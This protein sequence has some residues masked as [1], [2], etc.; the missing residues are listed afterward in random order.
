[1]TSRVGIVA[2]ITLSIV[3]AGCGAGRGRSGVSD[4]SRTSTVT[5]TIMIDHVAVPYT[6][7]GTGRPCLVMGSPVYYARVFSSAFKKALRCAYVSHRG[8]VAGAPAPHGRPF[9]IDAAVEEFETARRALGFDRFVLVGHSVH[10]LVAL[11]YAL[12]YPERVSHVIAIDAPPALGPAMER[13]AEEHWQTHA[14]AGRKDAD[15]LNRA[16]LTIASSRQLAPSD[17]FVAAYVADAARLWADSTYDASWLWRDVTVNVPRVEELLDLAGAY[18]LRAREPVSVPVFVAM[19][20]HDYAIPSVL[21]EGFHG[22]FRD[23]TIEI[24]EHSG[25]TPPLEEAA[26]FDRRVLGWLARR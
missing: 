8:Y 3:T 23:V 22:P 6:I 9:T 15:R 4:S 13:Q 10:G 11:A 20:R 7:E 19:G 26:E 25:H 24:F 21:W 5:G 1:M 16:R 18:E 12:R 14:S 17:S 2:V